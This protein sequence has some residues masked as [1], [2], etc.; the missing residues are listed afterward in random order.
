MD[1]LDS[2]DGVGRI[3]V[4]MYKVF[5]YLKMKSDFVENH[6]VPEPAYRTQLQFVLASRSIRSLYHSSVGP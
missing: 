2:R 1:F 4:F 3:I 6:Y 5:D